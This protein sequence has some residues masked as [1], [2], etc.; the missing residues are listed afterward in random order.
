[1]IIEKDGVI[2]I[3]P[4]VVYRKKYLNEL[5]E[6]ITDIKTK[7]KS[8]DRPVFNDVDDLFKQLDSEDM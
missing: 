2:Q 5:K 4:V 8:G 1:M 7:I 3:M 6:E